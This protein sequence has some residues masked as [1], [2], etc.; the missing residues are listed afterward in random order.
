MG[1]GFGIPNIY[2]IAGGT[3]QDQLK[4]KTRPRRIGLYDPTQGE[5]PD[6]SV[7]NDL[8]IN[9]GGAL[10]QAGTGQEQGNARRDL[11][12]NIFNAIASGAAIFGSKNPGETL[13][14]Q[15][16][17]RRREAMQKQQIEAE[18]QSQQSQ[19]EF[20]KAMKREDIA[21]RK[22]EQKTNI[23]ADIEKQ[24]RTQQHDVFM[25]S[26]DFTNRKDLQEAHAKTEKE[27][28]IL[29][30]KMGLD[31]QM[32]L[33][34]ARDAGDLKQMKIQT[35]MK[36][37]LTANK[38]KAAAPIE[39][40]WNLVNKIEKGIA[41]TEDDFKH[42]NTAVKLL[43][44]GE[45]GGGGGAVGTF[46]AKQGIKDQSASISDRRKFLGGLIQ[47]YTEP[48][49]DENGN[50][51]RDATGKIQLG[52]V[53]NDPSRMGEVIQNA[54]NMYDEMNMPPAQRQVLQYSRTPEGQAEMQLKAGVNPMTVLNMINS[55]GMSE[56]DK[57]KARAKVK[58]FAPIIQ[59]EQKPKGYF[60]PK[61][62]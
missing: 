52:P 58:Q 46:A 2:G 22:E 27:L 20:Q 48:Q 12:A 57:R 29:T 41:F 62:R 9:F 8:P 7:P 16:M 33:L 35:I 40:V 53:G 60:L 6:Y 10:P 31:N 32:A 56:E 50:P 55:S 54:M 5:T 45:G 43:S 11:L 14:E 4:K 39:S 21:A 42:V 25:N 49:Y 24:T 26:L 1:F 34:Q 15:L 59:T 30:S 13:M 19:I 61:V 3:L 28:A 18:Q 17:Q 38:Y 36:A 47:H 23:Q 44:K 37:M 51:I